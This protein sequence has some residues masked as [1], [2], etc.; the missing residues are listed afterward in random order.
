MLLAINIENAH[1]YG[2]VLPQIH[3]LRFREFIERQG[4]E[5]SVYK[6]M[7]F[8]QYDTPSTVYLAWVDN[9]SVV[10]GCSRFNPT[11][12]PYMLKDVW[13]DIVDGPLPESPDIWEGSRICSDRRCSPQLRTRI[14]WDI[15]LGIFEF[16]FD[17]DI[18]K[19]IAV[20]PK[21]LINS[22]FIQSQWGCEILGPESTLGRLKCH[23]F[24]LTI[25]EDAHQRVQEATDIV[26]RVLKNEY[27][28]K[29]LENPYTDPTRR[30]VQEKSLN[31]TLGAM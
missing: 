25:S 20:M 11:D 1:K 26:G 29:D 13:P 10:R 28:V 27:L 4:Y 12:R 31:S 22:T 7:E 2:D 3:R 23:A 17:N 8:D 30:W 9:N 21:L 16:C 19:I 15:V 14:K 24:M 18:K 5:V 6:N